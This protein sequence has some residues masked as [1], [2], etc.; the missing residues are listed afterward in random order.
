MT[1]EIE[2][3]KIFE[4]R[5]RDHIK[6]SM[7]PM[8]QAAG[9]AGFESIELIHEALP[10]FDLKDVD[11]TTLLFGK[12]FAVPLFVS[13]MTSGHEQSLSINLKLASA[14]QKRN[15]LMGVGSQR[16]ELFDSEALKEWSQIRKIVGDVQLMANIGMTQLK[17]NDFD[18]VLLIIE[19]M[20]A[21][22]IFIH[23][24][25]LQEAL[26]NEGTPNFS[27]S[28]K[29]LEEF[30]KICP[31]PVVLKEV[32]CGFSE[33][34]LRHLDNLGLAAIDV[35]GRGGTHWGKIETFRHSE[36]S[37]MNQVGQ[38]FSDWGITTVQ[39][40]MNAKKGLKHTPYWASG[41]VRTGVDAA[42]LIAMGTT[43]VGIAQPLMKSALETSEALDTAMLK[44]ETELKISMFCTGQ[45]KVSALR[46]N[47]VWTW[48]QL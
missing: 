16:R 43:M 30:I 23:T 21:V 39:S 11:P 25:P 37:L 2:S 10:Q 8:S 3:S 28:L 31:V 26:Q 20:G 17:Q 34:T 1:P 44:L 24:N 27:G 4:Q 15:W 18:K 41:G 42:K 9:G 40:V 36:G 35:A 14:A 38:S 47:E 46:K 6:V 7:D 5:K 13:S 45:K 12:V 29:T 32:G 19:N 33:K 22:G 48:K